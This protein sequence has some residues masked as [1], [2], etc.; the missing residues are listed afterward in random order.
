MGTFAI[1]TGQAFENFKI[2]LDV[3]AADNDGMGLVWGYTST[4][5][6]NRIMMINDGWPEV[7]L[8]GEKGPMIIA[9]H[10]ISDESPWYDDP[11]A[12]AHPPEYVPFPEGGALQHW[13]LV[14]Q[15]GHF[16]FT[17]DFGT[18]LEGDAPILEGY[19]GIQLYAM[20]AYFDNIVI[21]ATLAVDP[22]GK[23]ATTWAALKR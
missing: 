21:E 19:V 3:S 16:Q 10:R 23:L 14:V 6:H 13:T 22:Q 12:V 15:D 5:S 17:T 9:H 7:P 2:D 4:A 8:D 18:E 11:L 1:F 20:Q